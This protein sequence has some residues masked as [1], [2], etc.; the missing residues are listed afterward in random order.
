MK[1]VK[2]LIK[3]KISFGFWI[4]LKIF[5]QQLMACYNWL[6]RNWRSWSYLFELFL[7]ILIHKNLTAVIF[8]A[9]IKFPSNAKTY[10]SIKTFDNANNEQNRII[11]LHCGPAELCANLWCLAIHSKR[12]ITKYISRAS[13]VNVYGHTNC[14]TS[15]TSYP[16]PPKK[17]R[18]LRRKS[19]FDDELFWI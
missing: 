2:K 12:H 6:G 17:K 7:S 8:D 16:P 1:L 10:R 5:S 4:I 14:K 19:P 18:K 9:K 11:W 3:F 13:K 15:I